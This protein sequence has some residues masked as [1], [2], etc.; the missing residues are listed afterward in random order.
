MGKYDEIIHLSRPVDN[1]HPAMSLHNRAAQF[2]PFDALTGFGGRIYETSRLTSERIDLTEDVKQTIN[3]RLLR[4]EAHI[5]EH[6]LVTVTYFLP[7]KTKD[8]GSYPTVTARVLKIDIYEERLRLENDLNIAFDD[9]MAL[10]PAQ[11]LSFS[12]P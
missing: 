8:G 9:I 2:A 12:S 6:P 11:D 7:D 3:A 1:R 5:K 4:I 10:E